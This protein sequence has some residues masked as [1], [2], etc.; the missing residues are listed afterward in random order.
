MLFDFDR[1]WNGLL[2]GA[3]IVVAQTRG[4]V[5]DPGRNDFLDATGADHLIKL[6]VGDRADQGQISFFLADDL[7]ASGEWNQGLKR[8]AH[9]DG[10]A[11]ADFEGDSVMQ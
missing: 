11:V 8:A 6:H 7:V 5:A 9:R 3:P 4:D 2:G 10:H 1:A